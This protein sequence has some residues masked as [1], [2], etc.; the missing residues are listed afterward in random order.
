MENI[1]GR[2]GTR[3]IDVGGVKI[4]GDNKIAV[5]SMNNTAENVAG[6]GITLLDVGLKKVGKAEVAGL[7]GLDNLSR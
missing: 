2:K 5:Q 7:V 1:F 3:V 6:L 4:G